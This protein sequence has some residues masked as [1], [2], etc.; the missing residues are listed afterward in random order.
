[1][2][3]GFSDLKSDPVREGLDSQHPQAGQGLACLDRS[4]GGVGWRFAVVSAQWQAPWFVTSVLLAHSYL[5]RQMP[6]EK[7]L[8]S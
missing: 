3:L 4:P 6:G 2:I 7:R 8:L 5:P 1:M